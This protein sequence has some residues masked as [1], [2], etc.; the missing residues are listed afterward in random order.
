L[1]VLA[2]IIS[3]TLKMEATCSSETPVATQRTTRRYI[4]EDDTLH[5]RRCENLKFYMAPW[6]DVAG[7]QALAPKNFFKTV[8]LMT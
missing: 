5:N 3:S 7:P 2:E 1:L 4:P 8:I 6:L